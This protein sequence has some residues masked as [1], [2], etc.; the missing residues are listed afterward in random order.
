MLSILDLQNTMEFFFFP[1]IFTK[2]ASMKL[3]KKASVK[4]IRIDADLS[5]YLLIT[6]EC[7][8]INIH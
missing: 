1:Y 2:K 5:P 8:K 6:N 4:L 3:I 7:K